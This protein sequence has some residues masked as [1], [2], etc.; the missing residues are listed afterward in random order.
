M[1]ALTESDKN[2]LREMATN[3]TSKC[4]PV[5]FLFNRCAVE[6]VSGQVMKQG[7]NVLYHPA[8]W[9]FTKSVAIKAAELTGTKA[10]FA[11]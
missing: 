9:K 8:Y 1:K 6:I 5:R 3:D 4:I 10:V 11:K 2:I 7:T